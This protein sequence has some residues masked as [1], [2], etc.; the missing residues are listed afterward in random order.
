M[1]LYYTKSEGEEQGA[2]I[3]GIVV[4]LILIY[5]GT[6]LKSLLSMEHACMRACVH[7]YDLVVLPHHLAL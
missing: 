2:G 7:T 3:E 5:S 4:V 6:P 1:C